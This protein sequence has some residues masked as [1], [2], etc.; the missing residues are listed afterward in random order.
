MQPA[1]G[2]R[3]DDDDGDDDDNDDDVEYDD[4]CKINHKKTLRTLL[5]PTMQPA[6]MMN[7]QSRMQPLYWIQIS[8]QKLNCSY[9]I[10]KQQIVSNKLPR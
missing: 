10:Y 1:S 6:V 7:V 4:S 3:D 2:R 8:D 5:P 9:I